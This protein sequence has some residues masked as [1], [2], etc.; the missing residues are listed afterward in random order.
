[1]ENLSGVEKCGL[2]MRRCTDCNTSFH[3]TACTYTG[4]GYGV[5]LNWASGS[6]Q[7]LTFQFFMVSKMSKCQMHTF[8]FLDV[9]IHI[10]E[11]TKRINKI[12]SLLFPI[13]WFLNRLELKNEK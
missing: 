6:F 7:S 4:L 2:R 3:S 5:L 8:C 10:W 1:M 13:L 11:K 9:R 12:K